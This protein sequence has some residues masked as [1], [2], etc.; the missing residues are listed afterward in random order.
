M[1]MK[2]LFENAEYDGQLLRA[3]SYT[4]YGGAD[5][6]ECLTTARR[7]TEGDDD[8]WYREWTATADR[9]HS[10]AEASLA[11]GRRISAREAY[12]RA[13]NYY[14]AAYAFLYRA[15]VDPRALAALIRHGEAFRQAIALFSPP[16]EQVAIP[17][18]DA[19]L[20][21]YL[22]RV[23]STGTP[24]ATLLV[25]GGYDGTAE[26]GY[27]SVVGAL[28]R[29][30]NALCFDGPGQ[31]T[32][33]FT[34]HLHMRPDWEQVV[35]PVVDYLLTRP[36]VDGRRIVLVGRSWGGYLAPRA[37]SAEHRL[38]AC[39][40]DPGLLTPAAAARQM[41][42]ANLRDALARGDPAA[43]EPIFA[44]MMQSP[45]GAFTLRRGMLVHGVDTPFAY[46]RAMQP[47]TLQD[48]VDQI[49]CPT[50][51]TQAENDVRA[52]QSQELYDALRCPKVLV[53]FSNTDGAGEHCE[54]GAAALYDQRGLDWL[55]GVLGA[56]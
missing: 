4:Y 5:I 52:S 35:T 29:G 20:P 9:V 12:L 48:R 36:E 54:S 55:D 44:Q 22:Y 14:R 23:D 50:L 42:P 3:L 18:E 24:R 49:R 19:T 16:G 37:A 7:I 47:Y 28:R 38:A 43:L 27:F 17:Y 46:L 56:A 11:A 6:G 41:V 39:I 26:E 8:S 15:P 10:A 40:A 2:V 21:G 34:Q 1:A 32:V 30:Y 45:M 13:S 31:G 51:V 25:T 53:E 33:L